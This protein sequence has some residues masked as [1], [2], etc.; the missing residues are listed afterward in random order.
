M[1]TMPENTQRVARRAFKYVN[2]LMLLNWRLGM[3]PYISFW[4]HGIG[5]FLLLIH[6]GRK[7]GVQRRTPINYAESDGD[8]YVT[9]AFGQHTHWYKNIVAH[10]QVEVW[11][12]DAWWQAETEDVTGSAHHTTMLREVLKGSGFAAYMAGI[13]PH[14]M[15]DDKL[16]AATMNYRLLR[17]RRTTPCIGNG[18]PGDLIWVWPMICTGL[19]LLVLYRFV[20]QG[21]YDDSRN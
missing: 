1:S 11:L 15:S 4:P 10:P 3:G 18:S 2:R 13:N 9:A 12:P 8:I 19:L 7:S 6:T 16:N 14:T 21:H 5:H 17:M 20:R